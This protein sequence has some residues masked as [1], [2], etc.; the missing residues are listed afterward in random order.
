MALKHHR[1]KMCV[2]T[3]KEDEQQ[4]H[5]RFSMDK[6]HTTVNGEPALMWPH[7]KLKTNELLKTFSLLRQAN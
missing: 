2:C 3:A 5:T 7:A 4:F 6:H 1:K